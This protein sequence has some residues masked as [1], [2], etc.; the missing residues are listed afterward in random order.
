MTS[1][2]NSSTF[3]CYIIVYYDACFH[4]VDVQVLQN[5]VLWA[6]FLRCWCSSVTSLGIWV[7]RFQDVGVLLLRH[8][9][10]CRSFP[11][12]WRSTVTWLCI[13]S[14]V[15]KTLAFYC[16]VIVYY[17]A[18]F[19][20]V[21]VLLLRHC[22]YGI[23]TLVS[24]MSTFYCYVIV[25][26]GV[27]INDADALQ[28]RH[29]VL[30]R[31]FPRRWRSTVTS[32]C[33]TKIISKNLTFFCYMCIITLVTKTLTLYCYVTVTPDS[34]IVWRLLLRQCLLWR[35]FPRC[36]HSTV[37]TLCI[38][39]AVSKALAFNC[40]VSVYYD[41]RFQDVDIQLLRLCVL[42]RQFPWRWRST[43]TSVCIMTPVSKTLTFYSY[44][45]V[46]HYQDVSKALTFNYNVSVYYDARFQDV[47]VLLL[48][49]CILWRPFSKSWQV[50]EQWRVR[51]LYTNI[52]YYYFLHYYFYYF[53]LKV[54][55]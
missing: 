22:V 53:R 1:M 4:D 34:M 55:V 8:C 28:F 20:D 31:Y 14:L 17:V 19:Q 12:R 43:V 40:N 41:A 39:T 13:M 46:Y 42:L 6:L 44:D 36:W 32:F 49:Q 50:G 9:V 3:Y 37:T 52:Y 48:G 18:R 26:Y 21:G 47:D 16:Y 10:S 35:P 29:C 2:S 23:M 45:F 54:L 38:I 15:L 30:W 33:I 25:Y 24:K 7:Y 27:N 11:R 51:K 5:C